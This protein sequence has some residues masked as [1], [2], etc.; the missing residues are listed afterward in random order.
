[1]EV[2]RGGS[3]FSVAVKAVQVY[4]DVHGDR[5]R[6]GLPLCP[7]RPDWQSQPA[8][9]YVRLTRFGETSLGNS[10][11]KSCILLGWQ[12]EIV[13]SGGTRNGFEATRT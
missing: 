4:G 5:L 1:M 13:P 2:L 11:A 8:M 6:L 9:G 10:I 3:L 12:P 7:R